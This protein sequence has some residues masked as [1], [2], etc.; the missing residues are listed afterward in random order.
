MITLDVGTFLSEKSRF[1][2]KKV[3]I[4]GILVARRREKHHWVLTASTS[5]D[6]LTTQDYVLI[7][8]PEKK[9]R[10]G[11][12]LLDVPEYCTMPLDEDYQYRFIDT[13]VIVG[14]A[15]KA[16]DD[17]DISLEL[18]S[19]KFLR[20]EYTALVGVASTLSD[21]EMG[22]QQA[23]SLDG[24]SDVGEIPLTQ[25]IRIAGW[26]IGPVKPENLLYIVSTKTV[27][28]IH[29]SISDV[30]VLDQGFYRSAIAIPAL[31]DVLVSAISTYMNPFQYIDPIH[32][33]GEIGR[34]KT[35]PGELA[36]E[37]I[38]EVAVQRLNTIFHFDKLK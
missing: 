5:F 1:L 33:V 23:H 13:V 26:V 29:E 6:P 24:I 17:Q 18:E 21:M 25:R 11:Y 32:I 2:G 37:K 14:T 38:T 3:E 36:M 9:T 30:G 35:V 15:I 8:I 10:F 16:A 12:A 22:I 28:N 27:D 34:S 4:Q 7:R 20:D 19:I 31:Y